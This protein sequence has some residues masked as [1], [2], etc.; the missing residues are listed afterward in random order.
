MRILLIVPPSLEVYGRFKAAA[1]LAAQPQ[2]PLGIA[3]IGA[4]LIRSGHE[5]T[6]LDSDVEGLDVAGVLAKLAELKPNLVGITATTPTYFQALCLIEQMLQHSDVLTVL[7]G[8]HLTALPQETMAECPADFGIYGEGE[9]TIVELAAALEAGKQE[10]GK[11]L[12]ANIQGLIWRDEGRN[13]H[14]NAPRPQIADLDS[15]PYPARHLLNYRKYLWSVPHK[16]WRPVTSLISQ[17]G[18]PYHC[19]FCCVHTMFPRV[20]YRKIPAV[21]DEI[22]YIVKELGIDHIMFQDDTLTLNRHKVLEMCE[23]IQ[24]R[25]LKFTWEGYTRADTVTKDLLK[26]MK[27]AGLIRLSFGVESGVETI[28]E[29]IKKGIHLKDLERVYEWASELGLETRCSFMIGHPFETMETIKET[30]RFVNSLRC[31]QA[32]INIAMPYPGSELLEMAKQGVGGLRL[33]TTDWHEY[34]RYGNAVTEMNGLTREDLIRLQ[35]WAYRSFYLRPHIIWYNLRR[36][37]LRS[38]VLNV[39]AFLNSVLR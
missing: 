15:I 31:Y 10:Q 36:A 21:V 23:L 35:K 16:G 26:E 1:R 28:L 18:C 12:V 24:E 6:I 30:V 2:M 20:R 29:A 4:V 14:I 32:Y 39:L 5:V 22:E 9:E 37:D 34:R 25:G 8:Y 19:V 33:L 38:A 3:Y 27:R 11:S 7:G 13:I 17:R